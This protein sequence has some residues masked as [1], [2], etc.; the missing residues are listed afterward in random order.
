MSQITIHIVMACI[1][2]Q[3]RANIFAAEMA[4]AAARNERKA[5]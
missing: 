1:L 2:E 3:I 4:Y 5:D